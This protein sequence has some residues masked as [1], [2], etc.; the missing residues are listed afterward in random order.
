MLFVIKMEGG[1]IMKRFISVMFLVVVAMFLVA[2]NVFADTI[3]GSGSWQGGWTSSESGSPFW[4]GVS[5][6]GGQK[7]IGYW[8]SNTGF[9]TGGTGPGTVPY[10]GSNTGPTGY[11]TSFSFNNDSSNSVYWIG[12]E[13][14]LRSNSDKDY[15][16]M[17]VKVEPAGNGLKFTLLKEVAGYADQN[18]FGIRDTVGPVTVF[19]GL[20]GEGA[21]YTFTPTG[22]YSFYITSSPPN[23]PVV[24]WTT[25]QN[26]GQFAVFSQQVPEPTTLLLLGFGLVGLAGLSRKLRK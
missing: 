24:T 3:S 11:D 12:V 26:G 15:N 6:D 23:E 4:A 10:W 19:S 21:T 1:K 22:N 25:L 9:F 2:P 16:D 14:I 5:S 13:D 17:I 7:N 20:Q 8:I 18:E